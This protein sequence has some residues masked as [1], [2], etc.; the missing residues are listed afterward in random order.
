MNHVT[1][2]SNCSEFLLEIVEF[3]IGHLDKISIKELPDALE[4]VEGG[5]VE[6][7]AAWFPRGMRP[8]SNSPVSGIGR[9]C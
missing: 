7:R 5:Q 1:G 9:I 6:T 8:P 4:N 2:N 3:L